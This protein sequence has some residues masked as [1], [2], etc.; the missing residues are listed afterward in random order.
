MAVL[1]VSF[2]FLSYPSSLAEFLE[3]EPFILAVGQ[4]S[5]LSCPFV[6]VVLILGYLLGTVELPLRPHLQEDCL[7]NEH[8]PF[9]S[10]CIL[11]IIV[12][13]CQ[14]PLNFAVITNVFK[15][16]VQINTYHA[17]GVEIPLFGP[18]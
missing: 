3:R 9:D 12:Q 5:A 13:L 17:L 14:T 2:E 4:H 1:A 15:F 10:P 7:S 6:E 8:F 18:K 16:T 11:M